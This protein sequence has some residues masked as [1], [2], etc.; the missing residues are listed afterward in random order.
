MLLHN[1]AGKLNRVSEG[2]PKS[3]PAAGISPVHHGIQMSANQQNYSPS[4][5][6]DKFLLNRSC[7]RHGPFLH[8]CHR[9]HMC[10]WSKNRL[11]RAARSCQITKIS[12][13]WINS[14]KIFF[15]VPVVKDHLT[16]ETSSST[17]WHTLHASP[18]C[19]QVM[20]VIFKNSQ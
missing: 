3:I 5:L 10:L 4:W 14:Y 20:V 13:S 18:C 9:I 17:D 8:H 16:W 19:Y 2:G 7:E 6:P 12:S 1:H 15:I 11:M